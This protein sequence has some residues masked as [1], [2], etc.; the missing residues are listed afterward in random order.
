MPVRDHTGQ[1]VAVKLPNGQRCR[2]YLMTSSG[3]VTI[4]PGVVP[5]V[6]LSP[7]SQFTSTSLS[8][9][10]FNATT[11]SVQNGTPS[12]YSWGFTNASGGT[13]SIVG[14]QGTASATPQVSGVWANTVASATL[15]CDVVIGG[16]TYRGTAP[17]SHS[18]EPF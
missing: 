17:L 11:A 16:T 5:T 12:S 1:Q 8:S 13:C 7:A 14:G 2:V 9:S 3:L 6:T 18:N 10:T 4:D 15:Y